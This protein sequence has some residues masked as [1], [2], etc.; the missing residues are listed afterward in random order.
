[1]CVCSSFST[2][3]F[4]DNNEIVKKVKAHSSSR[5][6][7]LC[8]ILAESAHTTHLNECFLEKKYTTHLTLYTKIFYIIL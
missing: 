5:H 2:T 1:M 8:M 4:I 3:T 6:G 7:I